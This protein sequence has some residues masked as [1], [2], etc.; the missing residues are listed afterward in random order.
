MLDSPP[1]ASQENIVLI[2]ATDMTVFSL[3]EVHAA[4]SHTT[5]DDDT[6]DNPDIKEKRQKAQEAKG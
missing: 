4:G 5:L 1:G 6:Q 2:T 3:Q